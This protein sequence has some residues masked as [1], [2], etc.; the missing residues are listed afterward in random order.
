[1]GLFTKNHDPSPPSPPSSWTQTEPLWLHASCSTPRPQL[2]CGSSWSRTHRIPPVM[3]IVNHKDDHDDG[4][5][6]NYEGVGKLMNRGRLGLSQYDHPDPQ[7]EPHGHNQRGRA[8][9]S[10]PTSG[11]PRHGYEISCPTVSAVIIRPD[12][13]SAYFD[14]ELD[15]HDARCPDPGVEDVLRAGDVAVLAQPPHV[16]QEILGAV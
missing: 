2:L 16:V 1:M 9:S 11:H 10:S 12:L 5:N 6:H 13:V 7:H 4:D 3:M 14:V 8:T 15:L